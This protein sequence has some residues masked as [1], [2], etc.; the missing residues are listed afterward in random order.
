LIESH[1]NHQDTVTVVETQTSILLVLAVDQ[2][3]LLYVV[4][5]SRKLPKLQQSFVSRAELSLLFR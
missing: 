4:D 3:E 1:V 2:L 5:V